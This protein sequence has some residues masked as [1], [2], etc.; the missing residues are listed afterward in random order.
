MTTLI[1]IYIVF[2]LF[3]IGVLLQHGKLGTKSVF[4]LSLFLA[5]VMQFYVF[6][7]LGRVW[8]WIISKI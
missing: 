7:S 2:V 4:V 1:I 8:Y 6:V 3:T 5:F